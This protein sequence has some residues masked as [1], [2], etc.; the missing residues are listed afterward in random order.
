MS[1]LKRKHED[2][3]DDTAAHL[4]RDPIT[5]KPGS[6]PVGVAVG[7]VAGGAAVG[8]AAGSV[9][10]PIGTLVG[11][12]VGVVA[13]G[14]AGKGVA[15]RLDPTVEADYWRAAHKHRPY[16]DP[17]KDY[18]RDY[19]AVYGFGLQAREAEPTRRW[20]EREAELEREWPSRRGSSTLDWPQARPAARDAWERA[21]RSYAAY[22][23]SDDYFRPQF[24]RAPYRGP[25]HT[26][27]D[28]VPAYRYGTRARFS[29]DYGG[30]LWDDTVSDELRLGWERERGGSRLAWD[31]AKG[32]VRDAYT[33][34]E[35]FDG[36]RRG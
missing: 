6:H 8:A 3:H 19:A 27:E 2:L 25:D 17:A 36:G 21:D 12:V 28:F 24:E 26:Y 16:Y 4:N 32:A 13:G 14:A 30:R 1:N 10:G 9:L 34:D 35:P 33:A 11:A 18:D 23:G 31:D 22:A 7:G 20:E 29:T 5:G 15:E